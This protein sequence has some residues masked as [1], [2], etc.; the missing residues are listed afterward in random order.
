MQKYQNTNSILGVPTENQCVKGGGLFVFC[1]IC[2]LLQLYFVTFVFWQFV[3]C[4]FVFCRFCILEF[5]ILFYWYFVPFVFCCICILLHSYFGNLF[6]VLLYFVMFVFWNFCILS[7][8]ILLRLVVF[9]S[10]CI[11]EHLH[12]VTDSYENAEVTAPTPPT[13]NI[14]LSYGTEVQV[15]SRS[16]LTQTKHQHKQKFPNHLC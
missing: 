1:S 10:V 4:D 2:I 9:C 12:F 16:F 8:C 5:C 6:F 3:F 11:M 15:L 7:C 13:L 14:F